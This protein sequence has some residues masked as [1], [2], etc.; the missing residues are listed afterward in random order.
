MLPTIFCRTYAIM[1]KYYPGEP[2]NTYTIIN[3]CYPVEQL[4]NYHQK[5]VRVNY[6]YFFCNEERLIPSYAEMSKSLSLMHTPF[7]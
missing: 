3:K 7:T 6:Q 5:M 1:K 4:D 2:V